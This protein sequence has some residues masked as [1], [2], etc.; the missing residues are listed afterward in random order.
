LPAGLFLSNGRAVDRIS[1]WR[2]VIDF[3]GYDLAAAQLAVDRD[4]D[5]RQI[6]YSAFDL[7]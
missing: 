7:A 3:Q 4:I 2:K 5:Q 1:A 6:A